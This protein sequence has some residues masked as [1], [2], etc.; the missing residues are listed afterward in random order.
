[1]MLT[2]P[3]FTVLALGT[4]VILT[5]A[6]RVG[7]LT[8][9]AA[10]AV[11]AFV[12]LATTLRISGVVLIPTVAV[13]A[14]VVGHGPWG[15]A[16]LRAAVLS[17]TSSLGVI[18]IAS[19]N[20]MLG[21]APLGDRPTGGQSVVRVLA[22]GVRTLGRY[23]V[24]VEMKTTLINAVTVSLGTVLVGLIVWSLAHI[25]RSRESVALPVALFTALWWSLLVYSGSTTVLDSLDDRLTAPVF[26]ATAVVIALGLRRGVRAQGR[27]MPKTM[28][29]MSVVLVVTSIFGG[30]VASSRFSMIAAREGIGFNDVHATRSALALSL[31]ALP[32]DTRIASNDPFRA[33]WLARRS[34]IELVD[35]GSLPV[36]GTYLVWF[37][38]VGGQRS[39][40]ATFEPGRSLTPVLS[41]GQGTLIRIG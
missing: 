26:A 36:D 14:F 37:T 38:E 8:P 34:G 15:T 39:D 24:P 18:A 28:R 33:Y 19:R 10:V 27:W 21:A 1:M 13:V 2:E 35:P 25:V 23:I 29:A 40:V 11:A 31:A 5:S 9:L 16:V 30:L 32:P 4:L 41:D 22:Q 7:R 6:M 20:V 17:A 3:L 12:S